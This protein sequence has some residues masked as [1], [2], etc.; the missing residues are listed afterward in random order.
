MK[1]LALALTISLAT[2]AVSA[3]SLN[4]SWN[5][6]A[7]GT[8]HGDVHFQA[9][10]AHGAGNALAATVTLFDAKIEMTGEAKDGA[11]T[12]AGEHQGGTLTL[13]GKLKTDG[14]LAGF[15][16]TEQGDLTWTGTRAGK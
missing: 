1:T 11:F 9:T 4:G 3:H 5:L 6:V 10:F 2:V 12:V 13:S 8:P 15:M 14:T 16:S 7:V